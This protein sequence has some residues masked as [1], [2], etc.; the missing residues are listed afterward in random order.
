MSITPR[1]L[2]SAV[3]VAL[4]WLLAA[5]DEQKQAQVKDV[6]Q[7][8]T[9]ADPRAIFKAIFLE[10]HKKKA[11]DGDATAQYDLGSW[12]FNG[13]EVSQDLEKAVYWWRMAAEQE[14]PGAMYN[15]GNCYFFGQGVTKDLIEAAK[16]FRMAADRG[17]ALAQFNLGN[18]YFNGDGVAK[19]EVEAVKW[20][21]KAAK[22][23]N[24]DAQSSLGACY[25]NGRGVA[26]DMVEAVKSFRIAA[27]QGNAIA[28]YNLGGCYFA[29]DG[30][31]KDEIEA[32]AYWSLAASS[33]ADARTNLILLKKS[34]PAAARLRGEQRAMQLKNEIETKIAAKK[35]G[36]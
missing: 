17:N 34:L 24:L 19:D 18:S 15:L 20:F 35:A 8:K 9:D 4:I 1:T 2:L 36:R 32:Y 31:M 21:R 5:C 29:G 12:Y 33:F 27:E 11:M 13:D 14:V 28:Q 3:S 23:G 7:P 10:A 25:R 26:Q 6:V 16:W 30:V 22:Q